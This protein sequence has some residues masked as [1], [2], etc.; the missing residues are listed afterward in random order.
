MRV[1]LCCSEYTI[2]DENYSTAL[3]GL[4][5]Y[6]LEMDSAANLP[7]GTIIR[8]VEKQ[9]DKLIRLKVKGHY[10]DYENNILHLDVDIDDVELFPDEFVRYLEQNWSGVV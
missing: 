5:G 1:V 9:T 6:Y 8:I 2:S 4:D 7:I 3:F 10:Y